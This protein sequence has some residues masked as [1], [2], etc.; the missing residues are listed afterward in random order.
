M[1]LLTVGQGA[2]V[3][4]TGTR[5]SCRYRYTTMRVLVP[6]LRHR[7]SRAQWPRAKWPSKAKFGV[8]LVQIVPEGTRIS[9]TGYTYYVLVDLARVRAMVRM[10]Y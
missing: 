2:L 6:G 9:I 3:P 5:R 4:L 8:T 7:N 10:H 1:R